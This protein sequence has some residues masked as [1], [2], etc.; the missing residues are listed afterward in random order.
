MIATPHRHVAVDDLPWV[1]AAEYDEQPGLSLTF[2]EVQRL[3]GLTLRD[4]QEVLDYLTDTGMLVH[5]E[6]DR[7]RRPAGLN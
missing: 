2:P 5:D 3:W 4:C 1:I 7:Y 6:D